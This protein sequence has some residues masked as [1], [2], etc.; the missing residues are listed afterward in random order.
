MKSSKGVTLIELIIVLAIMTTILGF[1][2]LS[3][4]FLSKQRINQA[5]WQIKSDL[6]YAQRIAISENRKYVVLFDLENN[7]YYLYPENDLDNKKTI[8]LPNG[9][10]LNDINSSSNKV[11]YTGTGTTSTPCT[12]TIENESYKVQLTVNLGAGRVDVKAIYE[13]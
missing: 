13:I 12:I 6:R 5:S 8:N 7:L 11:I 2:T 4:S 1:V 9:V 10:Y 3:P